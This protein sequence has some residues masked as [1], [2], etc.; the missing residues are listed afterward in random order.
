MPLLPVCIF[1]IVSHVHNDRQCQPDVIRNK[2]DVG[3]D[4]RHLKCSAAERD[5]SFGDLSVSLT[6]E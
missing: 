4:L 3:R 1:C 6:A 2:K 5:G